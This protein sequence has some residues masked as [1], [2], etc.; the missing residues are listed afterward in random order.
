[1]LTP[2]AAADWRVEILYLQAFKAGGKRVQ[3]LIGA[4]FLALTFTYLPSKELAFRTSPALLKLGSVR[5]RSLQTDGRSDGSTH[6]AASRVR[7]APDILN[8]S[9]LGFQPG[10][11]RP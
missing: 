7:H 5:P 4:L 3:G 8:L 1:M 6:V 9:A 11:R 10:A 2:F